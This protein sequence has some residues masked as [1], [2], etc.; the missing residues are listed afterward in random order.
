MPR[1]AKCSL[2]LAGLTAAA[3]GASEGTESPGIITFD[4]PGAGTVAGQ[5][6]LPQGTFPYGINE[7]GAIGGNFQDANNVLHGFFRAPDGD[8]VVFDAPGA[9][10]GA[11]QGT[12]G[13]AINSEGVIVGRTFDAGYVQHGMLRARDGTLS[14]FDAP[15]ISAR[16]V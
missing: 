1:F 8:I 11:F 7:A 14:T 15:G 6:P 5:V 4:A 2:L 16:K 3:L 12:E 10:T 9:G 13:F